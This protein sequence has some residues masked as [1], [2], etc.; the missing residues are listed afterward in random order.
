MIPNQIYLLRPTLLCGYC[1]AFQKGEGDLSFLKS[2]AAVATWY[3]AHMV[4]EATGLANSAMESATGL[5][6]LGAEEF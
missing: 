1:I 6:A 4:P 3:L 2:K 5:Y